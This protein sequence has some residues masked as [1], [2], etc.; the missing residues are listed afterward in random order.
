MT[1][2]TAIQATTYATVED[3]RVAG[4]PVLRGREAEVF[5]IARRLRDAKAGRGSIL[6]VEG[7]TGFGKTRLLEE[8]R[9]SAAAAGLGVGFGAALEGDDAVSMAPLLA[10]LFDGPTPVLDR[11]NVADV[12]SLADRTSWLVHHLEALLEQVARRSPVV[13]CLDDAQWADRETAAAVRI[14]AQRLS[15]LPIV[16]LVAFRPNAAS[17][18]LADLVSRLTQCGADTLTL[19]ALDGAAIKQVLVDTVHAKPTTRLLEFAA[20]AGGSPSLV[21]ELV[22]GLVDEG[23]VQVDAGYAELVECRVPARVRDVTRDRLARISTLARR[24]VGVASFL[25]HTCAFDHMA[26]MLDVAPAT[27][28]GP[29]EELVLADV[30]V[31]DGT[32]LAFSNDVIREAVIDTVPEPARHALRRQAIEVLVEAGAS[33]VEPAARLA[34]SA[35]VGDRGAISTLYAASR[36]LALSDPAVAAEL[37]RRAFDL[38]ASGDPLRGPLVADTSLLL[39]EA[40]RAEEGKALADAALRSRLVPE[41]EAQVRMS[42]AR[43]CALPPDVRIEAGRAALA[44]NDLSGAVRARHWSHLVDNVVAAG[45][46]E[47]ARK[48][49]PEAETTVA[50]S[51]DETAA[52]TLDVAKSRLSYAEGEFHAALQQ[53]DRCFAGLR[54]GPETRMLGAEAWRAELLVALDQFDTARQ[55]ATDGAAAARRD[56]QVWAAKSWQGFRGRVL[57]QAGRISEAADAFDGMLTSGNVEEVANAADG[58]TLLALGRIAIHTGDGRRARAMA[59]L[60]E[61]VVVTGAPEVR[62]HAAWFLA[63]HALAGGDAAGARAR[64]N[65][66]QN[67]EVGSALPR[68]MVDVCDHPHLARL[69]LAAGDDELARCAV[70]AAERRHRLNPGVSSIAAA[71]AHARGLLGQDVAVLAKATEHL[72]GGSRPLAQASAHEDYGH[73]L[74]RDGSRALG[75]EELGHAL[76]IYSSAGAAWDAAR[77]RRRLR[78]LGIRRRLVKA[79]RPTTGWAG[80]TDAELGVV[81]L[82]AEGLTNREVAELLFVSQH[83]VGMHL[84]HAFTKLGINSRVELTRLSFEQQDAA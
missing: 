46:P 33:P 32:K 22:R 64:L 7:R 49:L 21:V 77:V 15:D 78:D 3:D 16:W 9:R 75:V 26:A 65:G 2:M 36:A 82:V 68:L 31:E 79:A 47:V 62:R 57:L 13:L 48:L 42:V 24:A 52:L 6:L 66:L 44:I 84:R 70:A 27:L 81:R 45:R 5:T 67:D 43:M 17:K 29:V 4:T 1:T 59:K 34:T 63:L 58:A 14:L 53:I 39:H 51:G 18:D 20:R 28:L 12:R 76:Q 69:A 11:R 74:V 71:A 72:A 38:T 41:Q 25:G 56:R 30:L 10:A 23:S 54:S 61:G 8:A 80:L 19:E 83:T 50:S 40:D 35:E 73:Q 55:A 60:A 37:G